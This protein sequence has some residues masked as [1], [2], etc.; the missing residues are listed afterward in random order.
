MLIYS[1]DINSTNHE[2]AHIIWH[3]K[4]DVNEYDICHYALDIAIVQIMDI[5]EVISFITCHFTKGPLKAM[6]IL[7]WWFT[8][9]EADAGGMAVDVEPSRQ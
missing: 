6:P 8:T 4:T 3:F 7:L 9:S 2:Y 1:T 5:H